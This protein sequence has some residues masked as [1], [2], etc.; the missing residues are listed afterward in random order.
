MNETV[1]MIREMTGISRTQLNT[2]SR[3]LTVRSTEQNVA[4]A[5]AILRQIETAARRMMLEIEIL[6]MNPHCRAQTRRYP[7]VGIHCV[8]THTE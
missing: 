4:L 7:A 5:Q 2:A 1:R 3:T 8:Y 6:E